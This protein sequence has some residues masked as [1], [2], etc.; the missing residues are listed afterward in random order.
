MMERLQKNLEQAAASL[1]PVLLILTVAVLVVKIVLKLHPVVYLFEIIALTS[2]LSYYGILT[3]RK[4]VLFVKGTDEAIINI[5]RTAK[6]RCYWLHSLICMFMPLIFWGIGHYFYPLFFE[7]QGVLVLFNVVIYIFICGL[8]L[9]LAGDKMKK[10]GDLLVWNSE[11]S[12]TKVLKTLKWTLIGQTICNVV[13][14]VVLYFL[15]GS[16][17][18]FNAIVLFV[19]MQ[20]LW[21]FMYFQIRRNLLINEKN[22]IKEVELVEKSVDVEDE[23]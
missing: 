16:T 12:K 9:G 17:S 7:E 2:S 14:N 11:K 19:I 8:P 22:A 4:N 10:K 18:L 13:L 5:R 23:L 1:Y 6:F 15:S 20:F 21:T 3:A